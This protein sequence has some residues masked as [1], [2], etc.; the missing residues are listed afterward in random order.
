MSVV[1]I[2]SSQSVPAHA[3]QPGDELRVHHA[4][5]QAADEF[6]SG[7]GDSFLVQEFAGPFGRA[8]FVLAFPLNSRLDARR[9][10]E[11]RPL[12]VM[13]EARLVAALSGRYARAV[14]EVA[15][16]AGMTPSS[17]A[18]TARELAATGHVF[19]LSDGRLR[20]H[21]ALAPVVRT[22]AYEAKV[23]EWQS[24]LRQARHYALWNRWS[25][26]VLETARNRPDLVAEARRHGLGVVVAGR[27]LTAARVQRVPA[28]L[29]L[30]ASESMLDATDM[31]GE[32]SKD[33]Q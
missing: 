12:R 2:R 17:V 8:D 1:E 22:A 33:C 24:A 23:K 7:R 26:V 11:L 27:S 32:C 5:R 9:S 19:I 4:V 3:F 13:A 6:A 28:Y 21:A 25:T 10:S 18:R 30:M 14:D 31:L 20:R 29:R 15:A 16:R